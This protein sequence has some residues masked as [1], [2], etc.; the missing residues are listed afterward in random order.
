MLGLKK[1]R[2]TALEMGI[3]AISAANPVMGVRQAIQHSRHMLQIGPWTKGWWEIDRIFVVAAGKAA[4][5]MCQAAEVALQDKLTGGIG[6]T[7][8][9]HSL[10]LE[11]IVL[12]EAGHPIPDG[13][14][15]EATHELLQMVSHLSCNDVVIVLLSGGGSALLSAPAE[16]ITLDDKQKVNELLLSCGATINE[17]NCVRKHLSDIKGGRLAKACAPAE[18]VSLILSDV[19]DDP[20]DVIAS[21][22]TTPDPTTFS[23]A[24]AVLEKYNVVENTPANVLQ[25]LRSGAA[26]DIPETPKPEEQVFNHAVNHLVGTNAK[27]LAAA[28][29]TAIEAGYT[30]RIL[31]SSLRGEA[32]EA[33]RI[34]CSLAEGVPADE[35]PTALILGG[36]TTVSLGIHPGKGGR[37]Q[38]L[39]LAAASELKGRDDIIVMSLGTDGTDGPTDA[40]GAIVDG[41]TWER[42]EKAGENIPDALDHHDAYPLLNATGDLVK[43]GPTGTNVMDIVVALVG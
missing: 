17:I 8:H 39:A 36:E 38:E 2:Q 11:R 18:I 31:T 20:L 24:L 30:P 13:S 3:A 37:N 25:R 10:P 19:I 34:I 9:G 23:E 15:V 1:R 41:K 28:K 26:G 14:S 16:G 5:T 22:P 4:A 32:R 12:R 43:T 27:A 42:A 35:R 21:G 33:A 6:I 7:K 40:A 29:Q